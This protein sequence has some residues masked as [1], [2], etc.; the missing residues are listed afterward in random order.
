MLTYFIF[1]FLAAL[2]VI[3]STV[4]L[5]DL[6]RSKTSGGK[7]S[8][9]LKT[10]AN[11]TVVLF[12]GTYLFGDMASSSRSS[13]EKIEN[14]PT[15][16]S[17][18]SENQPNDGLEF[19]I[20]RLHQLNPDEGSGFYC[21]AF[22]I[23][24]NYAVT[25]GHCIEGSGGLSKKAI[26]IFNKDL[27]DTK[28]TAKAAAINRR[29]DV[30]LIVGDF[31]KFRKIKIM[32]NPQQYNNLAQGMTDQGPYATWV[33]KM[34]QPRFISC[35]YPYGD[36]MMCSGI[37]PVGLATFM[38]MGAGLVFPGMSGGP[39]IDQDFGVAI[40]VNSFA[41]DGVNGFGSLISILASF[42]IEVK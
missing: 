37:K 7:S 16:V 36:T 26:V 29:G 5:V 27:V 33:Q 24:N 9:A 8:L 13:F 32:I 15:F 4:S 10:I 1:K 19:P 35:G 6:Y 40:G 3:L 25:A 28:V 42:Q 23:S 12:L 22:V 30:G 21:S 31:T 38:I 41:T 17:A 2:A 14:L 11:L 39:L 20:I 18:D 34:G